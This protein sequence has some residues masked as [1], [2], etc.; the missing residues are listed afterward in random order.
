MRDDVAWHGALAV[1]AP[2]LG[3]RVE[4]G[5]L[6]LHQRRILEVRRA[7]RPGTGKLP[8]QQLHPPRL[9]ERRV[10]GNAG[11]REELIDA[12]FVHIRALPQVERREMEAEERHLAL[13]RA[14]PAHREEAGAL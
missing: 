9:I 14:Q 5:E 2:A 8:R 10:A 11:A 1:A 12:R 7:Q 6:L 4:D 13:E 3:G